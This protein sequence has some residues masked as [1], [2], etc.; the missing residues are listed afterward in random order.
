MPIYNSP[1]IT[2]SP[3]ETRRYAGLKTNTDFPDKLIDEACT[4]ALLHIKPQGSWNTYHYA[5]ANSLIVA[6]KKVSLNGKLIAKHLENAA[7]VVV[8]ATTIGPQLEQAV[9][10]LF[11]AGDYTAALL[12]D[13]A[14]TAA[15]EAMTDNLNNLISAQALSRGQDSLSRFSPGYGDWDITDQHYILDLAEANKI[16]ISLT[17][18]CMLI[19]RKS[20]TAVI[21]LVNRG[22]SHQSDYC[23]KQGC[24]VC[25]QQNCLA[26]K[27]L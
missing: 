24:S 16:G 19:P 18:S 15:V 22:E 5:A 8:L 20:V 9:E 27:E 21:G 14:G 17:D 26:K 3:Q 7:E 2:I 4:L 11:R 10:E 23:S 12:L 25:S 6:Q 1:L 13:A